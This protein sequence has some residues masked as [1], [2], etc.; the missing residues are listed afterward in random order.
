MSVVSIKPD[1]YWVGV[2]DRTTDLF[3][4]IWP[5]ENVGVSYN[6][7]LINDEKKAIIDLSKAMKTDDYFSQ[8]SQIMDIKKLDYLIV[9]HMEPDHTGVLRTLI[10]MVPDI[11]ILGT[12]KCKEMMADF[13][14]ITTNFQVVEDGETL[15][16]GKRTLQFVYTPFVHWPETMVTYEVSTK[17]L[18]SCDAFGGYG[19]LT[20]TIFDD[21]CDNMNF[22]EAQSLRYYSNIVSTF[23]GPVKK[24]IKKLN[25]IEVDTICPSHGLVWRKDPGRIV[26][27]YSTW[28][29]WGSTGGELGVTLVY[30]SMY[31]N[32]EQVMN[33]V[34]HGVSEENVPMEIFDCARTHTSYILP[35][36]L[37]RK[38]VILGAPTYEVACFPPVR[39]LVKMALEKRVNNKDVAMFGSYGWSGG[40]LKELK[41]II[42]DKWNWIKDFCFPGGPTDE[43]LEKAAA[44]GR[45]FAKEL[46]KKF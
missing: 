1:I 18:F 19:A 23:A 36:M 13:Y 24:A 15:K 6:S 10:K 33:A 43:V 28:S 7:Y 34:A 8:I 37:K 14:Q 44:F 3:E 27:L 46:K 38:G 29:D 21:Q 12:K 11:K 25:G 35:S 41:S 39:N 32:T 31:G 2:N 17:T 42:G 30:G 4:G 40:A 9:N 5:I 26:D 22:Y 16:L 20:G 45:N